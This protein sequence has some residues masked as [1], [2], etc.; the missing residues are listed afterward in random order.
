MDVFRRLLD[1][2]RDFNCSIYVGNIDPDA[3]EAL[4]YELFIQFGPL[5]LLLM[6]KDRILRLHQGFAFV[7]YKTL[8]DAEFARH[9]VKGT[10]LY[11]R[12]LRIKKLDGQTVA[13]S[14]HKAP[15][16][17]VGARLFVGGLNTFIDEKYLEDV[18]SKFGTILETEIVRDGDG[19]SRGHGFVEYDNFDSSDT[20]LEKMD[21]TVLMSGQINVS[22]AFKD[23]ELKKIR[24]GDEAERRLAVNAKST[25]KKLAKGKK[26]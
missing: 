13:D 25:L 3:D 7:E 23:G 8:A 6:P 5:R 18:F 19:Q 24:H 10:R 1:V 12:A 4:I 2:E 14:G 22:Y 9:A 26:V 15:P 11:G 21:K 16:L 20:A 17:S